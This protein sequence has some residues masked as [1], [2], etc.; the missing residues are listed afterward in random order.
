[1]RSA[2][3]A[4]LRTSRVRQPPPSQPLAAAVLLVEIA[5][6]DFQREAVEL[7]LI[8]AMLVETFALTP[9]TAA[10][11]VDE[12]IAQ[13][14]RSVSLHEYVGTLNQKMDAAEKERLLGWLWQVAHADGRVDPYEEALIRQMADWL[15]VPHSA[16]VRQRLQVAGG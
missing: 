13:S 15:Y 3:S 1:M 4:W 14:Q 11:L 7:D 12:A 10:Q 5:K 2:L 6:A 16:F 9:E 8:R